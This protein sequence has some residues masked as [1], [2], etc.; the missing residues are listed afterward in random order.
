MTEPEAAPT[1]S[2]Q[3]LHSTCA[4][5]EREIKQLRVLQQISQALVSEIDIDDL[6]R[7]ILRSAIQVMEASAGSLILLEEHTDQL[8]FRVVEGGGGEQLEGQQMSRS[9]G[10]A[11]WVLENQQA[12]I[13]DDTSTDRRHYTQ[14]SESVDFGVTSMVCAPMTVQG[15]P[16]GVL[17]VLNKKS[18]ERFGPSDTELLLSFAA[19]SAIAIRNAQLYQELREEH[20]RIVT[21]EE[22]VRKELARDLHDGPTQLVAAITMNLQFVR[23]LMERDPARVGA[24][25][26][27]VDALA[28]RAMVQLRTMLFDLRPVILE[29]KGLVPTLE[30]YSTRLTETERFTVHLQVIGKVPPLSKQA[31]SATF[32]VVQEAISNAKK[33]AQAEHI[34]VT[35]ECAEDTLCCTIHDDG[36]GFDV[37]EMQKD[38]ASRGS[39]GMI[40]MHERAEMIQGTFTI[41]SE[42]GHGTTVKLVAPLSPN[43]KDAE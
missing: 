5:L 27:E 42:I 14:P 22:D 35:V 34:W 25:L 8:V 37:A 23:K 40:N 16:V 21:V 31:G 2:E 12:T 11:G 19:Q 32:A 36:E 39:L 38:Y 7:S 33:Y 3:D 28:A 1:E 41:Q 29:T 20:D 26:D 43:I 4:E 6:L 15:R 10:I 13:V 9:E 17:Q 24:E 18:G 30:A